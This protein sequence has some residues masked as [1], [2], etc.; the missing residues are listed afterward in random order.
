M[1]HSLTELIDLYPTLTGLAAL[2]VSEHLQGK[3][4]V[5]TLDDPTSTV[6]EAAFSVN[7]WR[8]THT[9]LLR[10][11]KWAFIQYGEDGAFGMELFDMDFDEKQYNN[12]AYH[13]LYQDVV[14]D[15]K[16]KLREKLQEVRSND[17]GI[18]YKAAD[19]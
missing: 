15:F 10:T 18:T 8:N 2:E 19:E 9:F 4:L 1:R 6:R 12:L 5:R 11:Q 14:K 13:P 3:S 16:K 7:V 17:L